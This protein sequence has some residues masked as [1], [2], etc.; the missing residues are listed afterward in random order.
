MRALASR[1]YGVTAVARREERLRGLAEEV[2]ARHGIRAEVVPA[3]LADPAS[4]EALAARVE[5]LGLAVEILVNN[6]GFG[7]HGDFVEAERGRQV[8]MVRVN[9]EAVVDL[10]GRY[11]PRMVERGRGAAINISSNAGF[12]PLPGAATYAAT[13]AL[14]LSHGEAVHEELKG[15][16]V[17]L[18]TVCPGPVRTEFAEVIGMAGAEERTP[19]F[20]WMSPEELAEQALKAAERGARTLVPGSLNRAVSVAGRFSPRTLQLPLTGRLWRRRW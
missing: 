2:R 18:T 10:L 19:G 4:R 13:K 7:S 8:E 17:T 6:A 14:V 5:E 12:Q 9:A 16:G 1:G 11:L 20:L 3:D 15:T